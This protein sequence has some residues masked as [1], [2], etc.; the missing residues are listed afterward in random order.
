VVPDSSLIELSEPQGFGPTTYQKHDI[1]SVAR[2]FAPGFQ[3]RK[4]NLIPPQAAGHP[5][6]TRCLVGSRATLVAGESCNLSL[7]PF[8]RYTQISPG[9]DPHLI[10]L[11]IYV[12]DERP[13]FDEFV[14]HV[15][16]S[17]ICEDIEIVNDEKAV[18]QVIP[19]V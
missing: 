5:L 13:N 1:D 3:V 17:S 2:G 14:D 4:I 19:I 8:L 6:L 11:S 16:P 10:E 9:S 7:D 15:A 12:L 18:S